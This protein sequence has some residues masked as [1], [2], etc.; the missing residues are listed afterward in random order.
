MSTQNIFDLFVKHFCCIFYLNLYS[1]VNS[2]FDYS[3]CYSAIAVAHPGFDKGW[4][5][6]NR[7]SGG[8][9]PSFRRLRGCGGVVPSR[10]RVL[11]F[12]HKKKTL[13]LAHFLIEKGHAVSAVT[14]DNAKII[15]QFMSKSR[16]LAKISERRL[17]PLLV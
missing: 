8:V 17:Q 14:T 7:G 16:S 1:V 2:R 10:Q 6:H 9:A 15:S 11:R 12:F 5:G 4:R 13:I 3:F